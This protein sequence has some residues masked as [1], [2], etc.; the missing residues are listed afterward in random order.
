LVTRRVEMV[1]KEV[2]VAPLSDEDVAAINAL[3]VAFDEAAL[4]GDWNTLVAFFTEDGVLMGPNGPNIQGR[5]AILELTT[6][7]TVTEHVLKFEEIDG[8]GDIA[9][10]KGTWAETF[11][12]DGVEEPTRDEGK[13]LGILRKQLDGSW[14]IAIWMW[15]SRLPLSVP[16]KEE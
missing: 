13:I 4:A 3:A 16:S 11:S 5:S 12:V 9:Y 6:G 14:L 10:A 7:L 8:Y 2:G 1:A 15:N